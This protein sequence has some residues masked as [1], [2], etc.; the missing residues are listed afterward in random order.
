M[1]CE[2]E[3]AANLKFSFG[4]IIETVTELEHDVSGKRI[5]LYV[6]YII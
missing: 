3:P 4:E 1:P 6:F 5:E 2:A